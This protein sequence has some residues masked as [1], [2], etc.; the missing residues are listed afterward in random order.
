M[1]N[2]FIIND[3]R[4]AKDFRTTTLGGYKKTEVKKELIKS[5]KESE[6]EP[7]CYWSA[8]LICSGFYSDLWDIIISVYCKHIHLGNP[9]M[10][11]YLDKRIQNFKEI[12]KGGYIGDELAMRNNSKI[13]QIFC[14]IICIISLSNK[15]SKLE[16][17]KISPEYFDMTNIKSKLRAPDISYGEIAFKSED[18]KE[19][20]LAVNELS[21]N[22]S[23]HGKNPLLACFWIE[24][25]ME[26][27]KI[28]SQK[29]QKC[30]CQRRLFCHDEKMQKEVDWLV[31]DILIEIANKKPD[32]RIK[33]IIQSLCS[34]Y[35]LKFTNTIYRQRKF[36]MYFAVTF[37]IENPAFSNEITNSDMK[38]KIKNVCSGINNVYKQ[39]KEKEQGA[40][41]DYLFIDV[42]GKKNLEKTREKLDKMSE[43]SESFIPRI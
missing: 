34:L 28:R 14:E 21:Y 33:S 37:L 42:G 6:I 30:I 4:I 43:I 15:K 26:Y 29:K 16:E 10:A 12:V 36:V 27:K 19:L 17:I 8:E 22:L 23:K 1:E 25:I 20:F 39:I 3:V 35:S 32:K 38:G 11:I 40:A 7:S 9:T 5:L 24:W 18:P 31:W 2:E 13:R 41:T